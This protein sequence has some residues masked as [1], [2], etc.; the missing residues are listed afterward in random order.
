MEFSSKNIANLNRAL[1]N[2]KL[3]VMANFVHMNQ[4]SIT[5]IT[6]KVATSLDL[7]TIKKY[8][9]NTNQIDSDNVKTS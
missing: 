7:Q 2:I 4:A 8:I 1:K 9:K 3:D 5:I 6:N